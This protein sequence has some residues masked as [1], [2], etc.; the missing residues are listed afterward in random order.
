MT[1][2]K[3][4]LTDSDLVALAVDVVV[5]GTVQGPDGLELAPGAD[6]VA[7]AF[8]GGLPAL[9]GV[10]GATGKA[11][12]VVKVPTGGKLAAPLLIAR[13][14]GQAGRPRRE[15]GA[16]APRGRRLGAGAGQGEE[17]G[18]HAVRCGPR[19]GRRGHAAGGYTF[20]QYKSESSDAG[21]SKVEFAS[22]ADGTAKEH[23]AA[24]KA[25]APSPS[26]GH[27]P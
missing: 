25:H 18:Q 20:T 19:R 5:I 22:P 13:R 7:A 1:A 11:E 14:P 16:G 27:H 15:H 9:L 12:E 8:D 24:L 2:P 23:K 3:L 10:L 6:A 17:G 4:A 21:L 26:A